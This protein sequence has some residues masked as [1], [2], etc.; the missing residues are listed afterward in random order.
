MV[1][2]VVLT[3][4]AAAL[5]Q[6]R[7]PAPLDPLPVTPA[8]LAA[9]G[10]QPVGSGAPEMTI[11]HDPLL[12]A[13]TCM[14]CHAGFDDPLTTVKPYRWRGSMHSHAYRDPIF[15]A[16]MTIA[17]QDAPG[18]GSLCI[19]CHAPRA[20]LEG[21]ATPPT[22][23]AD[24]S[25][26][27]ESDI[28]EGVSCHVCHRLVDP[29]YPRKQYQPADDEAI[30]AVLDAS[31]LRPP[32]PGNAQ[33]AV[34]GL[35][36][37]RGPFADALPPHEFA[38][39]PFHSTANLCGTCHDV[40]NPLYTRIGADT[41]APGDSY[42]LNPFNEPHPTGLKHGQFPEQ[43]TFSEWANSAFAKGGVDMG[44]RFNVDPND[45]DPPVSTVVSS[46]QDCHMPDRR[47]FGCA[48]F[49]EPPERRNVP[50]H[51]FVGA[52]VFAIDLLLH[53]HGPD[54]D[55]SFDQ[56]TIDSLRRQRDETIDMVQR[57]TD[58][59]LTQ[60]GPDLRVRVIN[61][62]GHK[63]L[64][65]MPEGRRI[66]K[67]VRF[68]AGDTLIAERGGYDPQ[69]ALLDDASTKVY[70]QLLGIDEPTAALVGRPAGPSFNL[71][72]VNR[73]EKDN[74]IPPRG[75]ERAAFE[76]AQAGHVGYEYD[77]GQFWDDTLFCIPPGATRAVFRLYYQTSSREYIEFLRAENTTDE[78]GQRLYD[79]W[80]AVG[81]SAPVVMDEG[82]IAL[83]P[84]VVGDTTADNAVDFSDIERVLTHWLDAGLIGRT[85]GDA[86]CDGVVD[87]DD[88]TF[89]LSRWGRTL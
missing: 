47:G 35:D 12:P 81:M 87:F 73:V 59:E 56:Y 23:A 48:E 11:I 38:Y 10:T 86:N 58:A 19:K 28:D 14:L 27:F 39:S 54:G 29:A 22:G 75:Y 57:A 44:G 31:G 85:G 67:N 61:Q 1:G 45:P 83:A 55:A 60:A 46:C 37:R 17:N 50:Y 32:E 3:L 36:I 18:A 5:A 20:W 66:W 88:I 25:V 33:M 24:G 64:T 76:A 68:Y 63:L 41:P 21:R 2:M 42:A 74:R 7:G 30:L 89:V 80:E 43:R 13:S 62:C 6:R 71:M 49:F 53:L 65:G 69:S 8:D 15:R 34:D 82:E 9:F 26:L 40:S 70:E 4:S 77:D 51:G 84:F 52:N 16:A 79:A 78:N 72:L